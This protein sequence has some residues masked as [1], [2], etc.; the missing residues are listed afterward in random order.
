MYKL[1]NGTSIIRLSDG[2]CIP[3]DDG[4]IDYQDYKLWEA[5]GN[6]PEPVDCAT[7]QQ[8]ID[9]LNA[10]YC[11]LLNQLSYLYS[12]PDLALDDSSQISTNKAAIKTQYRS[13]MEELE[14]KVEAINNG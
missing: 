7:K 8:K 10:E 3:A 11:V 12:K 1:T 14:Q 2:A 6:T 4:N 9:E 5:E 13:L